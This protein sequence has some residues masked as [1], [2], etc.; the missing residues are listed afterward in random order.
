MSDQ[1]STTSRLTGMTPAARQRVQAAMDGED[2]LTNPDYLF[3]TTATVLLQAIADG[4]IDPVQLARQQL[5][6][7]G[8]D[9]DGNWIGFDAAERL[10][11]GEARS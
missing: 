4:L 11:L 1:D 9:L 2:D 5:A 7:R 6:N 8:L 3:S 10:H